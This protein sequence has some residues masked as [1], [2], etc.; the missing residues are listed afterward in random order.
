MSDQAEV[1]GHG[2]GLATEMTREALSDTQSLGQLWVEIAARLGRGDSLD[3]VERGLIAPS[4]LSEE[5]QSAL[6]LYAWSHPA[7]RA[8]SQ[9]GLSAWAALGNVLLIFIGIYRY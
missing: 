1:V 3:S 5:E 7:R 2:A 9:A 8:T 4:G 6:W